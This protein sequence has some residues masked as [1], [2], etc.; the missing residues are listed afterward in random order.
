MERL[1]RGREAG[2]SQ[3][4]GDLVGGMAERGDIGVN[5]GWEVCFFGREFFNEFL[6]FDFGKGIKLFH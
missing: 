3:F 4:L 2:K 6:M 5:L 1:K